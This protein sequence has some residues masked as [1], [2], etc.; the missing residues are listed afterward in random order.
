MEINYKEKVT[1]EAFNP[2]DCKK[3]KTCYLEI[4]PDL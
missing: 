4:S 1:F 2:I 3:T